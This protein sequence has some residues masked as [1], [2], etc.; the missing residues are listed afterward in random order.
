MNWIIVRH[1]ESNWNKKGI[2][3]GQKNPKLSSNG[4]IQASK[5]HLGLRSLS[6]E[7]IYSSDLER[8]KKTATILNTT[9]NLPLETTENI[10]EIGF[11][12]WEGLKRNEVESKYPYEYE[13]WIN[14][15]LILENIKNAE[16]LDN[17]ITRLTQFIADVKLKHSDG[18]TVLV[19]SH[20]GT[21]RVLAKMLL[22]LPIDQT[23]SMSTNNAG[24]SIIESSLTKNNSRP[25]IH[26][27]NQITHLVS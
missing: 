16:N 14:K 24:I 18:K 21:I 2:F 17:L 6:I 4:L 8:A 13:Q 19:V 7:H 15:G 10:R 25:T 11:G 1:A 23:I 9:L 5:I 20:G 27:W 3:Q 12:E 26:H 22:G